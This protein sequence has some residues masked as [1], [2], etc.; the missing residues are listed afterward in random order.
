MTMI[1]LLNRS[2]YKPETLLVNS[3]WIRLAPRIPGIILIVCL[4][5][6]KS[7]N[8]GTWCGAVASILYGVFLWEWM[9]GMEKD[10]KILEPK[11]E[12]NVYK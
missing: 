6:I 9:A 8:A 2:L 7:L 4:P 1:A 12:D 11:S 10:W 5:L 3:R